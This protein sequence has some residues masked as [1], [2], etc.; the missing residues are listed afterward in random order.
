MSQAP[1]ELIVVAAHCQMLLDALERLDDAF[2]SEAP[3]DNL[4]EFCEKARPSLSVVLRPLAG[5]AVTVVD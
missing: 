3:I 1:S 5:R 2:A 4:C